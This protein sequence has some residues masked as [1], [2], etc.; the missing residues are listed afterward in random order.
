MQPELPSWMRCGRSVWME[1][2]PWAAQEA[3]P[4]LAGTCMAG[5]P[6]TQTLGHVVRA[7]EGDSSNGRRNASSLQ[8]LTRESSLP[9][10][11]WRI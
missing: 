4:A 10:F 7:T 2:R 1:P 3:V 9:T 5:K 8:K 6:G 11:E